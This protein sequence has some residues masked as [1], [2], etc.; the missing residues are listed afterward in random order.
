MI[1]IRIIMARRG[2]AGVKLAQTKRGEQLSVAG[3]NESRKRQVHASVRK[4]RRERGV[5]LGRIYKGEERRAEKTLKME[6]RVTATWCRSGDMY[7]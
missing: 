2:G 7:E 1:I 5:E 4:K 6:K 3:A